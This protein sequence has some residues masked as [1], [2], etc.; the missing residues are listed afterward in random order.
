MC[1]LKKQ[2]ER[3]KAWAATRKKTHGN[4]KETSCQRADRQ[5]KEKLENLQEKVNELEREL[6]VEK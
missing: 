2:G 5:R 4:E 6:K 1:F 3:E